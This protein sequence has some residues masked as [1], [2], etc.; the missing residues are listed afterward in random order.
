MIQ[1]K[2]YNNMNKYVKRIRALLAKAESTS[3]PAEAEAL[4]LKAQDLMSKHNI[5]SAE[6]VERESIRPVIQQQGP[7][8]I[9]VN[10]ATTSNWSFNGNPTTF[11]IRFR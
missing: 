1:V 11:T 5:S 6:L 2:K 7:T 3:F 8:I 4:R 10:T 9:F